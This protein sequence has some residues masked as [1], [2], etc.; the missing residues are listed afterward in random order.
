MFTH[1]RL[2]FSFLMRAEL[3]QWLR[4]IR[5][6][7]HIFRDYPAL[8]FQQAANSPNGTSQS[9]RAELVIRSGRKNATPWLRWRNKPQIKSQS[10]MV[11]RHR[12]TVFQCSFS[13][14]A[15]LVVTCSLEALRLWSLKTGEELAN[16]PNDEQW[17]SCAVSPDDS[18]LVASTDQGTLILLELE[19]GAQI[20]AIQDVARFNVQWLDDDRVLA[21]RSDRVVVWDTRTTDWSL[22]SQEEDRETIHD[23]VVSPDG[24]ML[25][26]ATNS[27]ISIRD[28]TT[29]EQRGRHTESKGRFLSC[30]WID[31]Q[32]VACGSDTHPLFIWNIQRGSLR[33]LGPK[34][35]IRAVAMSPDGNRLATASGARVN[36][37]DVQSGEVLASLK[38]HTHLVETCAWSPSGNLL[39]T[40]SWDS[41]AKIWD[42]SSLRTTPESV[43]H[44]G[45]V[46]FIAVSPDGGTVA[47][48]SNDT[49]VKL[50]GSST[51]AL[52]QT[53]EHVGR[54]EGLAFTPSGN[55]ISTAAE[56]PPGIYV[57]DS[58]YNFESDR[59]Q[60]ESLLKAIDVSP[61]G[62]LIAGLCSDDSIRIWTSD[63]F[64]LTATVNGVGG[65]LEAS[66]CEF[67]PDGRRLLSVAPRNRL[68]IYDVTERRECFRTADWIDPL[69]TLAARLRAAAFSPDGTRVVAPV[70]G[71]DLQVYETA[72]GRE[73]VR[74]SVNN[75]DVWTVAWSPDGELIAAGG[76]ERTI[77]IWDAGTGILCSRLEGHGKRVN[78]CAFSPGGRRLA[79][80]SLL[81]Q[82]TFIWDTIEG[83][84][85]GVFHGIAG[86][87]VVWSA[88]GSFI[89]VGGDEGMVAILG[90]EQFP[91][92]RRA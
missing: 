56:E 21:V 36:I 13:S 17:K 19:T 70:S 39:I 84:K 9:D 67:S 90:L 1:T 77:S 34:D 29:G 80:V 55:L 26:V 64:V 43:H 73:V 30:A 89:A 54:L 25:A 3:Q 27:G 59:R 58:R 75:D 23:C 42:A 79:S 22:L 11:L 53:L 12:S 14:T 63:W 92:E 57:W 83:T 44:S 28:L 51:G 65:N 32:T 47:S 81:D 78:H 82:Q 8:I 88:D 72:T 62:K 91:P 49:T 33:R 10:E 37:W 5:A 48:A 2:E 76:D 46:N 87:R 4:F 24:Q 31:N 38:E 7:S 85:P 66:L 50:W 20:A 41:T 35:W 60:I 15:E 52:H 74:L 86:K 40:G 45:E 18:R 69:Q 6:Q 16:F 61:D 68:F 71:G